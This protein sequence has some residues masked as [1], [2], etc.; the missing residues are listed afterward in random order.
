MGK[1]NAQKKYHREFNGFLQ[2]ALS[3]GGGVRKNKNIDFKQLFVIKGRAE[4][5]FKKEDYL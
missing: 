1:A 2:S 3:L 5:G 4:E